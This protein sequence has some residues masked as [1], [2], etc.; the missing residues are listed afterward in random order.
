MSL[1]HTDQS[2]VLCSFSLSP[3]TEYFLSSVSDLHLAFTLC[4]CLSFKAKK[5]CT[6][7]PC[8]S[9]FPVVCLS[10]WNP[11]QNN[12]KR[13][14]KSHVQAG[15]TRFVSGCQPHIRLKSAILGM[16][17]VFCIPDG[18]KLWNKTIP[19]RVNLWFVSLKHEFYHDETLLNLKKDMQTKIET[20][21][22]SSI[23]YWYESFMLYIRDSWSCDILY[24]L[25]GKRSRDGTTLKRSYQ[26]RECI[27]FFTNLVYCIVTGLIRI[28]FFHAS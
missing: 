15:S 8:H 24:R 5:A 7:Q 2:S 9:P 20:K 10:K 4:C 25:N 12:R 22:T 16:C 14:Q 13:K 27:Y 6:A 26:R 19:L 21:F 1:S 23:L 17:E 18:Q 28:W 11:G 3:Q